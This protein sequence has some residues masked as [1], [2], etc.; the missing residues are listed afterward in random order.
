MSTSTPTTL[1]N[2]QMIR[3]ILA[4]IKTERLPSVAS[5][6]AFTTLLALVPLLTV[7]FAILS[8][9]P[10]FVE[11]RD[12][13]ETLL[14]SNLAPATGDAVQTYLREF[15]GQAGSL[16]GLG[17][18]GLLVTAL[19]LLSTIEDAFNQIWSVAKGRTLS[20]RLLLYWAML[21]LG[22]ILMVI[23]IAVTTYLGS[24]VL[25]QWVSAASGPHEVVLGALPVLLQA[26]GFFLMYLI[27]PSCPV[28]P[29]SALVGAVVT[30]ALFELTKFGF[31]IFISNFDTY[32][33]IYGAMWSIPVFLLWIYL[34]WLVILLGACISAEID[35]R[36][37]SS[38]PLPKV[39]PVIKGPR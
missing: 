21:T 23:S 19:L 13:I 15:A 5:A 39:A 12:E 20:Q 25:G 37:K 2:R 7:M 8:M 30:L 24:N 17:L 9:F 33:I 6:L 26:L 16:T 36:P 29:R 34:S 38:D 32:Q 31:V 14:Y 1:W 27:V 3:R 22:P 28:R 10:F 11:W 18:A 35:V 4:R